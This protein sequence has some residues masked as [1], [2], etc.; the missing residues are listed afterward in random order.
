MTPS[1]LTLARP[2]ADLTTTALK[3]A[4]APTVASA[5]KAAFAVS[6]KTSDQTD[7]ARTVA[8]SLED[9]QKQRRQSLKDQAKAQVTALVQRIRTLKQFASDNPQV[10]AKQLAAIVKEL[11]SALK[12]YADAGGAP[13]GMNADTSAP[14]TPSKPVDPGDKT[15]DTAATSEEPST[16]EAKPAA[17]DN[18][19]SRSAATPVAAE[20]DPR[21]V[22]EKMRDSVSGSEAASDM[23]F[24]K[25]VRGI[26][27]VIRDLLTKAK[28]QT[29]LKAPDDE[30][31]KAFEA[32]EEGLK[33]VDEALDRMDRD[34]RNS[35]PAAGMFV[36]L[37]A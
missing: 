3:A 21:N 36:A 8:S 1:T 9:M 28:I 7:A 11:K 20:S 2:A 17:V 19:E 30:T 23:D 16:D 5:A 34:I 13:R 33:D 26:G 37:Y 6:A 35:S 31:R 27:K 29:A 25:L 32:T 22:Y 15:S 10:M 18:V 14:A 4:V 24:V 12:A